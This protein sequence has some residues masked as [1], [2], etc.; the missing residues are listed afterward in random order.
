MLEY[1]NPS[2]VRTY[3]P[4]QIMYMLNF[5]QESWPQKES[6]Y[7]DAPVSHSSSNHMPHETEILV[8]AELDFRIRSCG[9]SGDRLYKHL[10]AQTGQNYGRVVCLDDLPSELRSVVLYCSGVCRRIQECLPC[11]NK[12]C[13]RRGRRPC[14]FNQ[15][16]NHHR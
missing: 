8:M 7:T 1:L 3:N 6:N 15:Y 14:T 2:E 16:I 5:C 9:S 12:T 4:E 13:K 10:N 11:P